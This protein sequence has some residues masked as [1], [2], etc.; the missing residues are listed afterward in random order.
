MLVSPLCYVSTQRLK[1]LEITKV[2]WLRTASFWSFEPC[3]VPSIC[4]GCQLWLRHDDLTCG[5]CGAARPDIK[6]VRY[7]SDRLCLTMSK[8]QGLQSRQS[9]KHFMARCVHEQECDMVAL[10]L[11]YHTAWQLITVMGRAKSV[12]PL[13]LISTA[14]LSSASMS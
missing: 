12:F 11:S 14:Q 6:S 5:V 13:H 3:K 1:K 7:F 2:L 4:H 8:C 9:G 10:F